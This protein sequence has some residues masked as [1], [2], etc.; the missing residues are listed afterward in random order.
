MGSKLDT[1]TMCR[2][3]NEKGGPISRIVASQRVWRSIAVNGRHQP[4]DLIG[5]THNN[6]RWLPQSGSCTSSA[7]SYSSDSSVWADESFSWFLINWCLISWLLSGWLLLGALA[8]R[9]GRNRWSL[10]CWGAVPS[11]PNESQFNSSFES[12][13][14]LLKRANQLR[15][16]SIKLIEIELVHQFHSS[17]KDSKSSWIKFKK[18]KKNSSWNQISMKSRK[19]WGE[20][21]GVGEIEKRIYVGAGGRLVGRRGR[22]CLRRH[23]GPA[24]SKSRGRIWW[25]RPCVPTTLHRP[26]RRPTILHKQAAMPEHTPRTPHFLLL[27]LMALLLLLL[28]PL[29]MMATTTPCSISHRRRPS[30]SSPVAANK[31]IS[32]SS[33]S[34]SSSFIIISS[35]QPITST[36]ISSDYPTTLKQLPP[37]KK[38]SQSNT[39]RV[40]HHNLNGW[41]YDSDNLS[42]RQASPRPLQAILNRDN[43]YQS[44]GNFSDWKLIKRVGRPARALSSFNARFTSEHDRS[45]PD[46]S[47]RVSSSIC[48]LSQL[49]KPNNNNP[50]PLWKTIL[51]TSLWLL[52][53]KRCPERSF[54][55]KVPVSDSAMGRLGR[56]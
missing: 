1:I 53:I 41:N 12:L 56:R 32:Q 29:L 51:L 3:D 15:N 24:G 26:P 47:L 45:R 5:S 22:R 17:L 55:N 34:S 31:P 16:E 20:R 44:S 19:N 36:S 37:Q 9:S 11:F 30:H 4:A 42:H 28:L 2:L 50:I 39:V 49:T 43:G 25:W 48:D 7:L 27:L 10:D 52:W 8:T 33:H 38:L 21:G 14:Y 35:I 40:E 23:H 13:I 46:D 18:K 6:T 54:F